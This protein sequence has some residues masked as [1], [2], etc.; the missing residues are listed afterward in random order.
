MQPEIGFPNSISTH[1]LARFLIFSVCIHDASIRNGVYHMNAL[2][3][4]FARKRLCQLAN[5]GAPCAVRG[6][7][8]AASQRTK[9][10]R[11]DQRLFV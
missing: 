4:H 3:T 11:E 6:E 5:R 7:L 1:L 2:L 8:R 10:A 9:S